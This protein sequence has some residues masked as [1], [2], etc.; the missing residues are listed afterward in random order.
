MFLCFSSY[1]NNLKTVYRLSIEP[2]KLYLSHHFLTASSLKL[3]IYHFPGNICNNS[4]DHEYHKISLLSFTGFKNNQISVETSISFFAVPDHIKVG[5][6]VKTFD[7]LPQNDLLGHPKIKAFVS[8]M[9]ANGGYE[10]A[11]HGVPIS[12][13][14]HER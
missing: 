4:Y 5:P 7:W 12:C 9:G 8:H 11:Y 10:A 2:Q 3:S 1:C 13:L 14:C 6:N